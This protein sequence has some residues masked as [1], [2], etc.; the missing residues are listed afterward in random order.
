MCSMAYKGE[1]KA[2]IW[3]IGKYDRQAHLVRLE[4]VEDIVRSRPSVT[5]HLG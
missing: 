1:R 2:L 5:F 4:S 3:G